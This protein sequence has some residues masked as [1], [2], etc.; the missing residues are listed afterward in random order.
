MAT[1]TYSNIEKLFTINMGNLKKKLANTRNW[2]AFT[3]VFI[4]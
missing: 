1:V 4:I 3:F 2:C